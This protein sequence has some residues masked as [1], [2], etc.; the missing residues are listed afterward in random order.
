M[1][2][3]YYIK[4]FLGLWCRLC[5]RSSCNTGS[6]G[7]FAG[8]LLT[9][10]QKP[11]KMQ[12]NFQ[13]YVLRSECD[14][15]FSFQE[16]IGCYFKIGAV[17]CE[18]RGDSA[19]SGRECAC[20]RRPGLPQACRL[21]L[22]RLLAARR[23]RGCARPSHTCFGHNQCLLCYCFIGAAVCEVRSGSTAS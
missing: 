10:L 1:N 5:K 11:T 4:P 21:R 16:S 17:V 18:V 13:K 14:A 22:A 15:I 12:S 20:A 8:S 6:L 2:T 7:S 19:A 9:A 3:L 23:E